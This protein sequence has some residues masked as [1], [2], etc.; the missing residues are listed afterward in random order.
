M[1]K[2]I[3]VC[4][5]GTWN[6]PEKNISKDFPTNV[7]CLAR[8]I[9]PVS[10]DGIPQQVFYDWGLGSYHDRVVAGATGKGLHKNIMDG[11]RYIVQNYSP[12]D[13]LFLFGFSRGAYTIRSL[14]GMINNC[15]IVK[16]PDARLI[17]AAFDHYKRPGRSCKPSGERSIE[18]RKTYAYRSRRVRFVG[19]WDTVGAMGIPL[20][21]LGF[22]DDKDEFYDTELGSNVEIARHALAIDER[23]RDF[24]P[25]VWNPKAGIDIQQVWFLGAH[26]DIGGGYKPDDDGSRQSDIALQWLMREATTAG[27]T[28]EPHLRQRLEPNAAATIHQSRRW[29]YRLK[30]R[31]YRP[32]DHGKGPVMIHR[33]VKQ[34]WDADPNYRS[35]AKNLREYVD[36]NG[37]PGNLVG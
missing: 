25:T 30:K 18:F 33:S 14:C 29:Y 35:K 22:L 4:A 34:R 7:L 28:T 13:E 8:A 26:G 2:R 31:L 32:I 3:V 11:Y 23:R 12:G 20:S 36:A 5:D 21:F 27:L 17:Q 19:V 10:R 6:R 37:W 9:K 24:E 1:A 15:G 16:R